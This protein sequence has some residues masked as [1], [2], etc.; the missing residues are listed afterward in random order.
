M[1]TDDPVWQ[2]LRK[3]REG[4]GLTRARLDA[5]GAVMSALGTS[6]PQEAYERLRAALAAL[7]PGERATALA[8]D[9]GLDLAQHL[10]R[11]PT[12]P[13]TDWL[14]ERRTGYGRVIGRTV[15]TLSRWSD[16]KLAELRASLITDYFAGHLVV[17]A[18]VRGDRILGCTLSRFTAVDGGNQVGD[19]QHLDNPT[20]EPSPPC[21]VYGFP[22]DWRPSALTMGV[23]FLEHPYPTAV[24]AVVADSFF[25]VA[26]ARERYPLRPHEGAYICR[27]RDPRR[28][29]LYALWWR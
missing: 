29:R 8:V 12:G 25:E 18:A 3:L 23:S 28:D 21:L 7:G 19:S 11:Q 27:F 10:G 24:W 6:D 22:R 17:M 13:E 26:F 4:P 15:K 16:E 2:Q 9:F 5:S 20:S 14:M 1:D